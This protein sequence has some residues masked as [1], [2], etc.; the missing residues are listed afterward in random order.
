MPFKKI[1][2][3]PKVALYLLIIFSFF[4]VSAIML[5]NKSAVAK[6]LDDW[7]LL[8]RQQRFT[9]L[10]FADMTKL[11]SAAGAQTLT[12]TIHNVEHQDITYTYKIDAIQ[13]SNGSHESLGEGRVMVP[14]GQAQATSHQV[15]VPVLGPRTLVKITLEY[16]GISFGSSRPTAQTQS[17]NFW[18]KTGG[19]HEKD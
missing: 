8:P 6:Q 10:Y 17:I 18:A 9:E 2:A 5:A 1:I 16:Q 7:M 13:P 19:G 15:V 12:F 14:S 3:V 4:V 11:P